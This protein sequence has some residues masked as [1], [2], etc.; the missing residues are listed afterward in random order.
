M[1]WGHPASVMRWRCSL[2]SI[3]CLR[4]F[5]SGACLG[6]DELDW[7]HHAALSLCFCSMI[8]CEKSVTFCC[9]DL[10]FGIMLWRGCVPAMARAR[11]VGVVVGLLIVAGLTI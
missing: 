11:Q 9:A 5:A 2:R 10:R 8:L 4:Q 6:Q 1:C 3:S 7:S